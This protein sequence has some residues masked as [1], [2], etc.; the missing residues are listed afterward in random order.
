MNTQVIEDALAKL[1]VGDG[2]TD[3]ELAPL[4]EFLAA[5]EASLRLLGPEFTLAHREVAHWKRCCDSYA[6]S[7]AEHHPKVCA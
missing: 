3:A 1:K 4:T 2:L 7:R 6:R 5:T